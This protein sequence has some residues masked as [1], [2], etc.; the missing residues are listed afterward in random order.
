MITP[1]FADRPTHAESRTAILSRTSLKLP[2]RTVPEAPVEGRQLP[3][4]P[5]PG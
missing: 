1:R 4:A 5:T 3:R 2:R